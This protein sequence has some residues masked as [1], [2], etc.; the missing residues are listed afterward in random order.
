MI[1]NAGVYCHMHFITRPSSLHTHIRRALD[2]ALD[3]SRCLDF[4]ESCLRVCK[5]YV[6]RNESL[7][8]NL[9]AANQLYSDRVVA[10][11]VSKAAF[12]GKLLRTGSH[13]REVNL[14]LAHAALDVGSAN[15]NG[16]DRLLDAR[17]GASSIDHNVCTRPEIVLL[18]E[19]RCRGL[20][21]LFSRPETVGGAVFGSKFESFLVDVDS[22]DLGRAERFRDSLFVGTRSAR[23]ASNCC[24]NCLKLQ[25]STYHAH[26]ADR[27]CPIN[28][29][30]VAGFH[31]AL[32]HDMNTY[33]QG[34]N[35]G[36]FF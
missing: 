17:L 25:H 10:T 18:N 16:M 24:H 9:A 32:S 12:D 33:A 20:W 11:G 15:P 3:S 6:L 31:S 26:Q 35:D 22:N 27:T 23:T 8:V 7:H 34:F 2:K 36:A 5:L 1:G 30:T 28:Y 19:A 13:D 4:V 21:R 14:G 29:Y